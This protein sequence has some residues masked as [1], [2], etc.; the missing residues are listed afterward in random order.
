VLFVFAK[1]NSQSLDFFFVLLMQLMDGSDI[2]CFVSNSIFQNIRRN[3]ACKFRVGFSQT[4]VYIV[5]SVGIQVMQARA[6]WNNNGMVHGARQFHL[7]KLI[8][9]EI[10]FR[11]L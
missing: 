6:S 11:F 3:A 8:S 1:S 7:K 5:I 2:V 9:Q 4:Y 10:L